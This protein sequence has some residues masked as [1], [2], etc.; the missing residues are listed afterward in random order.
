MNTAIRF[1]WLGVC[2]LAGLAF[3]QGTAE[4]AARVS[5]SK[6]AERVRHELAMM[7]W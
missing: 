6:L 3:A 5:A 2:A 4:G 7:P 1:L